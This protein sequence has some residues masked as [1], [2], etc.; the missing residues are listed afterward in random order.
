MFCKILN[1]Y[2]VCVIEDILQKIYINITVSH[3]WLIASRVNAPEALGR[4]PRRCAMTLDAGRRRPTA[5]KTV[6]NAD[7]GLGKHL[8]P[9]SQVH[10]LTG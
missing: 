5:G 7:G 2:S 4:P 9:S 8:A 6:P 1:Y 3:P 10:R